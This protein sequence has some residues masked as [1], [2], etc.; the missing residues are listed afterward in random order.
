MDQ[1]LSQIGIVFMMGKVIESD[2]SMYFC[3]GNFRLL[4]LITI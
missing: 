4:D 1:I 2:L 3:N